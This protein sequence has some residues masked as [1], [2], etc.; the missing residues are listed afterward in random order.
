V[1]NSELFVV[2]WA[3]VEWCHWRL[4]GSP[5][6]AVSETVEPFGTFGTACSFCG[7]WNTTSTKPRSGLLRLLPVPSHPWSYICLDFVTGLPPSNS[8]TTILTVIDHFSKAAHFVALPK[9]LSAR[10]R[11]D[12]N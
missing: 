7:T 10:E 5:L 11:A 3:L 8:K 2:V 6:P 1:D 12:L 9:L 4:E